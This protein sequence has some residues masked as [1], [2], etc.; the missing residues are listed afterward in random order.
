MLHSVSME[1]V[2][3]ITAQKKTEL[4]NELKEFVVNGG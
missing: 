3:M 2:T 1:R 4:E